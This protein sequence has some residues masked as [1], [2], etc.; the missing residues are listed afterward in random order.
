MGSLEKQVIALSKRVSAIE[1]HIKHDANLLEIKNM[2]AE[3][4]KTIRHE[5]RS[6]LASTTLQNDIEYKRDTPKLALSIPISNPRYRV[7]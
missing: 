6:G 3:I 2:L 4:T 5:S 7:M 1:N